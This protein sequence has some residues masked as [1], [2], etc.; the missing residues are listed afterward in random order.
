MAKTVS[1][2][3][4]GNDR[5]VVLW[6]R[7]SAHPEGEAFVS[8][9]GRTYTVGETP[10]VKRLVGEGRLVQV[11]G[12]QATKTQGTQVTPVSGLAGLGLTPEQEQALTAAGYGDRDKLA[13]AS[14]ED[15]TAVS[16]VGK[17][18]VGN[19]RKALAQE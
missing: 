10:L 19:I 6:E 9:D 11:Q 14:D 7:N 16:G 1:V 8:S 17:A 3:G 4:A 12:T 13:A 5:R 2:K 15:L 18:T